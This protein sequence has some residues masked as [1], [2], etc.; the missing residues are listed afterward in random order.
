MIISMEWLEKNKLVLNCYEK[1]FTYIA[2]DQ[3]LQIVRGFPKL[4]SV[5]QISAMQLKKRLRKGCKLFAVRVA[6]L[7]LNENQT[8]WKQ[9]PILEEFPDV[10][11]EEIQGLPP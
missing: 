9:H 6:D 11:I 4:V 7:L 10:F 8:S 5:R 3:V 1:T 2:E